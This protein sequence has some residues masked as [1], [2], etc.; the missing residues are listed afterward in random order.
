MPTRRRQHTP[1]LAEQVPGRQADRLPE[2]DTPPEIDATRA[3]T[4]LRTLLAHD[5]GDQPDA[6]SPCHR[7]SVTQKQ[8]PVPLSGMSVSVPPSR[9]MI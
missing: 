3:G 4:P 8:A 7:A 5:R 6:P 9:L 1:G 2:A